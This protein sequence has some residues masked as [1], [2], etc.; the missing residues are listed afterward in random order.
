MIKRIKNRRGLTLIELLMVIVIIASGMTIV[1]NLLN[2]IWTEEF[3]SINQLELA[4]IVKIAREKALND[5]VTYTME[6][7]FDKRR[8][9]VKPI[10]PA[11]EGGDSLELPY[12][13]SV[14]EDELETDES[15]DSEWIIKPTAIPARLKAVLSTAGIPLQG[16]IVYIHF[17]PDGT[18]DPVILEFEGDK[19]PYFFI[20][21]HASRGIL[22]ES[23]DMEDEIVP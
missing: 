18:S 10:D 14:K 21:R 5:G 23:I 17:Y 12:Y 2:S 11:K 9:G 6:F 20:P 19:K 4:Q 15:E 1:G 13:A 3:Q 22:L 8:V 7:N 16:P